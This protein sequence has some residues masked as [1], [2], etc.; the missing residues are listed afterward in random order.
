MILNTQKEGFSLIELIVVVAIMI[1]LL[2]IA[3]PQLSK[4]IKKYNTEKEVNTLYGYLM[5]QRFKSMN[6]GIPHG[7]RFDS[8]KQYTIFTFD[9]KN[10]NLKFDGASEEKNPQITSLKYEISAKSLNIPFVI[11]FDKKG[12]TKNDT[13]GLGGGTIYIDYPARYNCITISSSRVKMGVWDGS[14]SKCEV[15]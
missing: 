5:N 7:I 3:M 6:T 4:Y 12:I 14:K 15:K 9:D 1:V 13:W 10:Y 2:A 8:S 11:L